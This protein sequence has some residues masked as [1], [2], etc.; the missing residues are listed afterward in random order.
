ME[1]RVLNLAEIHPS[2]Y[3]PRYRFTK[4]DF[5]YTALSKSI[6]RHGLVVP[7]LVNIRNM[8]L[9]SG[10]QRFW[11]LQDKGVEQETCVI[12][13]VDDAT[14]KA[15]CIAMNKISGEWD[16][17]L[18]AEILEELRDGG[19]DTDATGFR[20]AEISDILGEI[21][22]EMDDIDLGTERTEKKEDTKEGVKCMVGEY[23]FRFPQEEW[24]DVIAEIRLK[25]GFTREKVIEELQRRLYRNED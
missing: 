6:D 20:A 13:D 25:V 22:A 5:E 4:K 10:H 11:I 8:A 16:Y 21:E 15:L 23:S 19:Y 3:N 12:V 1:T 7:I 24:D 14:E 9:I 2:E 17:G 18:L